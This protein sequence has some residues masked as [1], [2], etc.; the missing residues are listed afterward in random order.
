MPIKTS[1]KRK[2]HTNQQVVS[3]ASSGTFPSLKVSTKRHWRGAATGI[4]KVF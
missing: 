4:P 3:T 1:I 2:R